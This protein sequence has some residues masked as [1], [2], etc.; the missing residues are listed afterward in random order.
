MNCVHK[1][2]NILALY[3]LFYH[4][5]KN[6]LTP[7][8]CSIAFYPPVRNENMQCALPTPFVSYFS[9]FFLGGGGHYPWM[10]VSKIQ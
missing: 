5:L 1:F 10:T 8:A 7:C 4:F 2:N 3:S 9:F 6:F